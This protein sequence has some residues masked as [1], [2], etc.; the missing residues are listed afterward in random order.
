MYNLQLISTKHY[1]TYICISSYYLLPHIYITEKIKCTIIKKHTFKSQYIMHFTTS[2]SYWST[3]DHK[4]FSSFVFRILISWIKSLN[5]WSTKSFL[6][7]IYIMD[8][9]SFKTRINQWRV[10]KINFSWIWLLVPLSQVK[11]EIDFLCMIL[12]PNLDYWPKHKLFSLTNLPSLFTAYLQF[13]VHYFSH[14][15]SIAPEPL[16]FISMLY[17]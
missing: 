15:L 12:I 16:L 14:E 5:R 9:C 2:L 4:W 7:I 1:S 10:V 3:L 17:F 13:Y 6:Q 11:V 8:V